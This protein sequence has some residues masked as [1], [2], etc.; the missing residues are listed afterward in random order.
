MK[1]ILGFCLITFFLWSCKSNTVPQPDIS[2]IKINL[3][4]ERFDQDFF[5][6][7]W[8]DFD[9]SMNVLQKKYGAFFSDF[10][11]N[12]LGMPPFP[13]SIRHILPQFI[14]G[15]K[16][17]ND[18][19]QAHFKMME[20]EFA[21]IHKGVQL[22]HYYFPNY[23]LPK[24]LITF[25]GPI[26]GYGNVL[27]SSGLAIGLQMYLGAD[28]ALYQNEYIQQVYPEYM[29]RK[30][31]PAYMPVN[32]IMNLVNDIAPR[33][34]RNTSLVAQMIDEGKQMYL[35][36]HFLPD[37][38]DTLI[39][40]YTADQLEGCKENEATIWNF[41]LQNNL[42]YSLDPDNIRDYASEGPATPVLGKGAP[43]NIGAFVGWQIV[44]KFMSENS[45]LSLSELV[46][47]DNQKLFE[48]SKYKPKI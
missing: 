38:S 33:N 43:G 9:G 17:I 27:T 37:L 41:F 18:T 40:G 26:D 35:L 3:P 39:L 47:M 19:V 36:Q 24:Q 14:N 32:T 48:R 13:D 45:K 11:S 8:T 34:N 1:R 30:F 5:G 4:I 2:N 42:L 29:T 7:N 10:N 20:P 15:Y 12:I 46:A 21:V 44:N 6:Q 28:N 22:V 16:S 31:T 23:K 25:V